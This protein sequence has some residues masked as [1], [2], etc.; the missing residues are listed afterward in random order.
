MPRF[1]IP[2]NQI[3]ETV[4]VISGRDADHIKVLRMKLGEPLVVCDGA[5]TDYHCQLS[6]LGNGFVEATIEQRIPSP[7]EASV[8]VT[9]FSAFS[10]G[11][12]PDFVVQKCTELGATAITFFP[13][14]RCISRPDGKSLD[15]KLTRWQRIAEEAAKQSGRG[16]IPAVQAVDSYQ[17]AL[18]CA[19]KAD[20]SLFMYETGDRIAMR[21]VI[22]QAGTIQSCSIVTG[23]EGGFEPYE[24]DLAV[25][26]GFHCCSMGPRILRCETAPLCGLT[27]VLYATG[28]LD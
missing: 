2:N 25:E 19:K 14:D 13:S 21:D 7:A 24:A 20:L 5:G 26:M 3:S 10:K 11:E 6:K 4:A 16:L 17:A 15:K 18:D 22:T 12:R 8:Q 9:I 23:P 28:N 1:F 27:A